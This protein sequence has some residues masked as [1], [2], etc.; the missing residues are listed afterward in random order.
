MTIGIDTK[1]RIAFVLGLVSLI[2][3][4]AFAMGELTVWNTLV[5]GFGAAAAV[6]FFLL[7]ARSARCYVARRNQIESDRQARLEALGKENA[8]LLQ[9]EQE[10]LLF[11]RMTDLLQSSMSVAIAYR[12]FAEYG[13]RLFPGDAGRLF[14]SELP[15]ELMRAA[16]RWGEMPDDPFSPEDCWALR[17][18]DVHIQA[19]TGSATSCRHLNGRL[20]QDSVCVPILAQGEPLALFHLERSDTAEALDETAQRRRQWLA[21]TAAEQIGLFLNNLRL[22]ETLRSLSVRD[23]VTNL[24][25]RRY[26]E[27]SLGRDLKQVARKGSTLAVILLDIDRFKAFNDGYGHES[28]DAVLCTIAGFLRDHVRGEDIACRYGGEEFVLILPETSLDIALERAEQLR[29]GVKKLSVVGREGQIL[30]PVSL[31]VGIS[32]FP[33]HAETPQALLRAADVAVFCAKRAGRDRVIT[34]EDPD[35]RGSESLHTQATWEPHGGQ[36][37]LPKFD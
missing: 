13:P 1:V 20:V 32:L 6:A 10:M 25:N 12:V 15:G 11:S 37:V 19:E 2:A 21:V 5:V 30:P 36:G 29:E 31:S 9:R 33:L 28:G 3:Q 26:M 17:R 16:V 8:G 23:P 35:R 27:E 22:Q 34:Y 4:G 14:V 7:A 18:G 24:F